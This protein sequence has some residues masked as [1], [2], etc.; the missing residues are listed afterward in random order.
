MRNVPDGQDGWVE[1][2]VGK[3]TP[4]P[5]NEKYID[6]TRIQSQYRQPWESR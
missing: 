3:L 1:L 5:L 2:T 6:A 4:I